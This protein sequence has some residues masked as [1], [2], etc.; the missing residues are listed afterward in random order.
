MKVAA[1]VITFN[2]EIDNFSLNLKSLCEQVDIIFVFDNGSENINDI[3]SVCHTNSAVVI[4]NYQNLGI[5]QNLNKALQYCKDNGVDWLLTMDQDSI[6][7]Q[8]LIQEF[9]SM[10]P[11]YKDVVSFTPFIKDRNLVSNCLDSKE[12]YVDSCITSG[13]L[14]NVD[15]CLSFGGFD[16]YYFIDCVDFDL[17]ASILLHGGKIL[18]VPTTSISHAVGEAKEH[19]L[20]GKK[21][22]SYNHSPFRNYY[23]VRNGCY[24]KRKYKRNREIKKV[25]HPFLKQLLIVW[26]Y[27]RFKIKKTKMIFKGFHDYLKGKF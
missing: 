12:H 4:K 2:P 19:K 25:E 18:M 10:M 27:E 1:S 8:N 26:L 5:S 3:I 14:I 20:F 24:F 6:C 21:L 17:S 11:K 9:T 15:F 7:S 23:I 16:E 13:N 22:I